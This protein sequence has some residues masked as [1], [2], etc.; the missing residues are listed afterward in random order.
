MQPGM[1]A[2]DKVF[3]DVHRALAVS[4]VEALRLRVALDERFRQEI[5]VLVLESTVGGGNRHGTVLFSALRS[6]CATRGY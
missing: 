3:R 1:Q 5:I 2:A 6:D 4:Q